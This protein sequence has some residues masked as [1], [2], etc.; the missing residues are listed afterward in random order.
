[1]KFSKNISTLQNLFPFASVYHAGLTNFL[2]SQLVYEYLL[3][4]DIKANKR[5]IKTKLRMY[6]L[7]LEVRLHNHSL[8]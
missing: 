3:N 5:L 8:N 7:I 4:H 2:S 6:V 1:M